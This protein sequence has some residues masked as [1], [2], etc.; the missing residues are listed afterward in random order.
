MK[1]ITTSILVFTKSIFGFHV[2]V[3]CPSDCP[4]PDCQNGGE[5]ICKESYRAFQNISYI[6][7]ISENVKGSVLR[8]KGMI[9]GS[10]F[11]EMKFSTQITFHQILSPL[12]IGRVEFRLHLRVGFNPEN[13]GFF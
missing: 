4:V 1:L 8:F 6:N 9:K 3:N 11:E 5:V 7:Q 10:K 2:V 13:D 12:A